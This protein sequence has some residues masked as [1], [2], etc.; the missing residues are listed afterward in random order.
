MVGRSDV[1]DALD[2]LLD[3][4]VTAGSP[5]PANLRPD[6]WGPRRESWLR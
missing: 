1:S 4:L 2:H 5:T 6:D 3:A